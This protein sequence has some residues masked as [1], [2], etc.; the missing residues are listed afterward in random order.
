MKSK[1]R[2]LTIAALL[3]AALVPVVA[4]AWRQSYWGCYNC[5]GAIGSGYCAGAG[6]EETGSTICVETG[7]SNPTWTDCHDAGEQCFNVTV[8]GGGGGG[9]GGGGG[10][11]CVNTGG[12]CPAWCASC[13]NQ[14][15]VF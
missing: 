3:C 8:H 2:L 6:H 4:G 7:S 9:T 1:G 12:G 14:P 5:K 10:G 13:T 15:P 11:G